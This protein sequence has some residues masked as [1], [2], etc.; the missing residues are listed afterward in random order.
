MYLSA[1]DTLHN[2]NLIQALCIH[3]YIEK[4]SMLY[5]GYNKQLYRSTRNRNSDTRMLHSSHTRSDVCAYYY[6]SLDTFTALCQTRV[7]KRGKSPL[8]LSVCFIYLISPYIV[9]SP[10]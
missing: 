10:V 3:T 8:C 4:P 5:Y 6:A 1:Y 9:I 7:H 2:L